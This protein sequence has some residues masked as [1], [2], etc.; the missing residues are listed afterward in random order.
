MIKPDQT[1]ILTAYAALAK[2][3]SVAKHLPNFGCRL[4]EDQE[5]GIQLVLS[6]SNTTN[7][8]PSLAAPPST[9]VLPPPLHQRALP[10]RMSLVRGSKALHRL[11]PIAASADKVFP[12]HYWDHSYTNAVMNFMLRFDHKL[13][14]GKLRGALERL[15]ERPDGWQKL[16]GRLRR[17]TAGR[18]D[19]HVPA[20]YTNQRPAV[21]YHHEP[22]D[23]RI[24]QHPLGAHI[25][26][27]SSSSPGKVHSSPR[28]VARGEDFLPLM[29]RPGDPTCLEDYL[30]PDD[31]T[32]VLG[33]HVVTFRDATL[34]CLRGSHV[35]FDAMG[36][37]E[38]LDAWSLTLQGRDDEVAPLMERDPM[39]SLGAQAPEDTEPCALPIEPYKH[40]EKQLG[41][42]QFITLGLR[43]VLDRILYRNAVEEARIVC[44]PKAYVEGLRDKALTE[45]DSRS[46]TGDD[47]QEKGPESPVFVSAG[48][49]L[50]A[51]W[52]GH[53]IKSRLRNA[54]TS[55][56]TICIMNMLGLRGHLQQAGLVAAAEKKNAILGNA[57]VAVP[58][59]LPARELLARPLAEVAAAL[60]SAIQGLGT[61]PQVE[62][63][64]KLQRAAH[65]KK[66]SMPALF[67]D[68][69][70]HMVVCTNWLKAGFFVVD[71]S[72][73]VISE[74]D[75][76]KKSGSL[77]PSSSVVARPTNVQMH[78]TTDSTPAFMMSI[79]S[80]L[81]MDANGD[82]WIRGSLREEYWP[83][84]EQS[85]LEE[86][87][88]EH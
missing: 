48:D 6:V 23:M 5:I 32:P 69:G 36:R 12:V 53:L 16:G 28:I 40:A 70:M 19:Y 76:L 49:I 4:S 7:Q 71:F 78:M 37:R 64:L 41:L 21:S 63:L 1:L 47:G 77:L 43:Q 22:Y 87:L 8:L 34:V 3:L 59:F 81:G 44:V 30:R 10:R 39:A 57:M 46:K 68:A 74:K 31:D 35:L 51:W 52:T 33:L 13:D 29:R 42:R 24:T 14:A 61:W 88:L 66:G 83:K 58:A 45:L 27:A 56:Q 85:L 67:G 20:R 86:V 26:K 2:S 75:D 17:N 11:A 55:S 38:L 9:P 73:A 80:I 18:L 62:A 82:Y 79:F 65:D 72:A 60:R 50:C 84:V 15:L 25:P 54:R